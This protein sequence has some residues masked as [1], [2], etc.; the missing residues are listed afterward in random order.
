[1]PFSFILHFAGNLLFSLLNLL[2]LLSTFFF[3]TRILI[4]TVG[5]M[6]SITFCWYMWDGNLAKWKM[7]KKKRQRKMGGKIYCIVYQRCNFNSTNRGL[8]MLIVIIH[9]HFHIVP[10]IE[11]SYKYER[12]KIKRK[13]TNKSIRWWRCVNFLF[14]ETKTHRQRER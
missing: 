1:M 12:K 6:V 8:P 11:L 13:R 3:L 14:V 5:L 10:C 2:C 4:G 7:R 9:L